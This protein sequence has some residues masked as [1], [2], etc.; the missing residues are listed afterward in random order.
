M[1]AAVDPPRGERA[2]FCSFSA[3]VAGVL[4]P[5]LPKNPMRRVPG[6]AVVWRGKG[7]R[8]TAPQVGRRP[9]LVRMAAPIESWTCKCVRASLSDPSRTAAVSLGV[10][11]GRTKENSGRRWRS[12]VPIGR[13]AT[14]LSLYKS[15]KDDT[16]IY[17]PTMGSRRCRRWGLARAGC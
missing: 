5:S 1:K 2:G 11:C 16:V 17:Q 6:L 8:T 7:D 9:R 4:G 10:V 15:V 13:V 14:G 12:W 3:K